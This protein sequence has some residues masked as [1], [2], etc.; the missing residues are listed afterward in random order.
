MINCKHFRSQW[1]RYWFK[2]LDQAESLSLRAHLSICRRCQEYDR[3]MQAIVGC[4][5]D[6]SRSRHND[7]EAARVEQ[8]FEKAYQRYR[9]AARTRYA[10]AAT[11]LAG[12]IGGAVFL[13][14]VSQIYDDS[15]YPLISH[16]QTISLPLA[17]V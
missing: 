7:L 14:A 9:T 15:S 13:S 3:Q 1:S 8:L 4:L 16:A 17:G 2:E 5:K 6:L 10:M 11:L 12:F